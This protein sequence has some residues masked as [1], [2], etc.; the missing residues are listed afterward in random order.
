ME[1][2]KNCPSESLKVLLQ[3][4]KDSLSI[5]VDLK[6]VLINFIEESAEKKVIEIQ[7]YSKKLNP[8][9]MM[10]LLLGIVCP[11][12]GVTFFMLGATFINLTPQGLKLILIVIFLTMFA[13]QYVAYSGFKFSKATL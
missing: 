4:L 8:L 5:G 2:A 11:S 3:R 13:F 12:L 7:G 6:M 9:V 1:W 10:Y